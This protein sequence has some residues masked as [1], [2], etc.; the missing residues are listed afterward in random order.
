MSEEKSSTRSS[1]R[2]NSFW[3][4]MRRKN[5]K[6]VIKLKSIKELKELERRFESQAEPNRS[7]KD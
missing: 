6:S 4:R 1:R 3:A 5:T 2:K 7:S